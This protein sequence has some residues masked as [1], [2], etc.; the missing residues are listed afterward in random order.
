LIYEDR[1]SENRIY[2][3]AGSREASQLPKSAFTDAY[4]AMLDV[5]IEARKEAGVTQSELAKRL[6]KPQPWVSKVETGVRRIDII[7]FIEI[8]DGLNVNSGALFSKVIQF[9]RINK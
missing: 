8:S 1:I 3:R 6:G 7:E 2:S 9:Y 4:K 5:L